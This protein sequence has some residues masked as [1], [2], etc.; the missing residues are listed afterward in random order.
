MK[1]ELVVFCGIM[2]ILLFVFA[3][4]FGSFQV[5]GYSHISQ[6]I[7]ESYAEGVPNNQISRFVGYIPAGILIALFCIGALKFL[8]KSKNISVGLIGLAIFYGLGTVLTASF[9]C[10]PGCPM[11]SDNVSTSQAIHNFSGGIMYALAP[12]CL[13]LI[14]QGLQKAQHAFGKTTLFLGLISLVFSY[15]ILFNPEGG[16]VGLMQRFAEVSF[17]IWFA[18]CVLNIRK[19]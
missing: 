5:E 12:F 14:G 7:S 18:L 8:P 6:Y 19:A 15:R 4:L 9:P 10:D 2:G 13:L 3:V 11:S 17:L 16:N 1:K